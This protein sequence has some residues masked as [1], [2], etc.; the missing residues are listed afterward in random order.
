M[1]R[2]RSVGFC[3]FDA[4]FCWGVPCGFHDV[5][6]FSPELVSMSHLLKKC[7]RCLGP[8]NA[9]FMIMWF[10][11]NKISFLSKTF[12]PK[13]PPVRIEYCRAL[14]EP[15]LGLSMPLS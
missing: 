11:V 12:A 8:Q 5:M 14:T 6:S 1:H 4:L 10:V 2:V 13:L 15:W 7:D 3:V 9:A